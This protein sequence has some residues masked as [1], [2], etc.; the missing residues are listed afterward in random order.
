MYL[1]LLFGGQVFECRQRRQA[2]RRALFHRGGVFRVERSEHRRGR[3]VGS[4][5]RDSRRY[6]VGRNVQSGG[7]GVNLDR[8][9]DTGVRRD[10]KPGIRHAIS[11]TRRITTRAY[12][13]AARWQRA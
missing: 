3:V 7:F 12:L 13:A 8:R 11:V 2:H 9:L 1:G 5:L 4:H 6:H 10:R